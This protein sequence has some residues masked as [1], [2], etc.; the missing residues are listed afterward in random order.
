MLARGIHTGSV[1]GIRKRL[2]R[3]FYSHDC[4]ISVGTGVHGWP[5]RSVHACAQV[6]KILCFNSCL[7]WSTLRLIELY[8]IRGCLDG[9]S[10]F[11]VFWTWQLRQMS[12]G[13]TSYI[14]NALS[15]SKTMQYAKR[16]RL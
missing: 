7:V 15:T 3:P 9:D 10:F 1:L 2:R 12:V 11:F 6:C 13:L 4:F 16:Y 5:G 8:T 14:L